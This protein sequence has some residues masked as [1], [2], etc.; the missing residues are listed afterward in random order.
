MLQIFK[1]VQQIDAALSHLDSQ[2]VYLATL[3]PAPD[4]SDGLNDAYG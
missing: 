2:A 4:S 1:L 3:C